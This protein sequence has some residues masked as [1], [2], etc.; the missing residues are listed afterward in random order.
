M[1]S[2]LHALSH[3]DYG[4]FLRGLSLLPRA[5]AWP[6]IVLRGCLNFIVDADWRTLSLGLRYVRP[7]TWQTMQMWNAKQT[8]PQFWRPFVLTLRR[9]IHASLE[10]YDATKLPHICDT[11]HFHVTGLE[12]LLKAQEQKIGVVLITAHFDS[13]YAGLIFLARQ[14]LKINLVSTN[15]MFD[16]RVPP[17]VA[18]HFSNKMNQLG[19]ALAPGGVFHVEDN[20]LFFTRA[21]KNGEIVVIAGDGPASS[22][23][24]ATEVNFWG[25]PRLMAPGPEFLAKSAKCWIGSYLSWRE[26]DGFHIQISKPTSVREQG[27]A[28]AYAALEAKLF[29]M[30]WRWWA[31]DLYPTYLPV[32]DASPPEPVAQEAAP[33]PVLSAS[34]PNQWPVLYLSDADAAEVCALFERIFKHPMSAAF[35]AWKYADGRGLATGMRDHEGR[36]VAHY[37]AT[38]RAMQWGTAQFTGVQVGD[39]MVAPEI[40]DV[41][42]KFG[43]FGR[44]AQGFIQRHLGPE[45]PYALGFGFPNQRAGLLG[46]R[47]KL[48][49][50]VTQVWAWHWK[51]ERLAA[52]L[53]EAATTHYHPLDLMQAADCAELEVLVKQMTV[54]FSAQ[55]LWWPIR[56]A[57]WWRHRYV[58]HPHFD[59]RIYAVRPA[60]KA[61]ADTPAAPLG[62]L[63]LKI[64]P[65][66]GLCELMDW[67]G[68][69]SFTADVL[70]Y[71]AHLCAHVLQGQTLE[72]WGTEVIATRLPAAGLEQAEARVLACEAMVTHEHLLGHPVA[73]LKHRF[74]LTGGDT[75]FR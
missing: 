10:E 23:S 27:V 21:L 59:Y 9:Y 49:W 74:W 70:A 51:P 41:F 28:H 1:K 13:L 18:R 36:L 17:S 2:I 5:W 58:H 35:R 8:K 62:A 71:A 63:V 22:P 12:D 11:S 26:A 29:E 33:P 16:A 61:Q 53:A 52:N 64:T 45:N 75:D 54:D 72:L 15:L 30:P 46:Q 25:D 7:A 4:L 67:I 42:A 55:S 32:P 57:D 43:P 48:Y 66:T 69:V 68:P 56:N 60:A 65:E 19:Q 38:L 50:P 14:G 24:R 40:R 6:L 47:L 3:L 44:V 20:L 37:G 39:V 31:A 34:A 73:A